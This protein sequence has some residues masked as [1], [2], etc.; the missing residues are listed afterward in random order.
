MAFLALISEV[1]QWCDFARSK[2]SVAAP[3]VET[4]DL[5]TR[6]EVFYGFNQAVDEVEAVLCFS[7]A[8]ERIE[9]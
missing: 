8:E 5:I 6:A 9:D 2:K 4:V 1:A 3:P 7:V